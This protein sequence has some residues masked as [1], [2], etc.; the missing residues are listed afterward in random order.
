MVKTYAL[1]VVLMVF[2]FT[3]C[4]SQGTPEKKREIA[5][6]AA[7]PTMAAT[8]TPCR[9]SGRT[10]MVRGDC[11]VDSE[12]QT[13]RVSGTCDVTQGTSSKG[14]CLRLQV[15]AAS[16]SCTLKSWRTDLSLQVSLSRARECP[17]IDATLLTNAEGRGQRA[18]LFWALHVYSE[19]R[20]QV[21][22]TQGVVSISDDPVS[23]D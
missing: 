12:G 5:R 14:P 11:T 9:Q 19:R 4:T 17:A 7:S 2:L 15:K 8:D 18:D 16:S 23:C 21:V 6:P 20:C 3:G 10:T 22:K 13:I 1:A